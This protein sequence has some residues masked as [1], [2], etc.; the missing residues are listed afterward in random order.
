MPGFAFQQCRDFFA[1]CEVKGAGLKPGVVAAL[2]CAP[3]LACPCLPGQA[4]GLSMD[5]SGSDLS[6]SLLE[7]KN[8]KC[9]HSLCFSSI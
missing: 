5:P 6:C 4:T 8:K 1:T 9:Y 2:L 3:A 7:F